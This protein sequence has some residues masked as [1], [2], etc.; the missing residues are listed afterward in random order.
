MV[1]VI[2]RGLYG[3]AYALVYV[4]IREF[5]TM[6][7]NR[8]ER[9]K[10]LSQVTAGLYA[11]INIGAVLGAIIYE[12]VGFA[13]VFSIAAVIGFSGIWCGEILLYQSRAFC[14]RDGAGKG[15]I[16]PAKRFRNYCFGSEKLGYDQA[17]SFYH[18][19]TGNY[20]IVF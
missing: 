9:S 16:I 2:A 14:H 17:G 19:S 1:L 13:G 3:A 12:S 5:A 8:D 15:T 20:C 18:R 11:G 4:S 6:G 10:G 7:T